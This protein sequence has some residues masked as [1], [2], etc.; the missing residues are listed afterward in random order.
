MLV[1]TPAADEQEP[2]RCLELDDPLLT[3]T[4]DA[5]VT[6]RGELDRSVEDDVT[7]RF[8]VAAESADNI[9]IDA[10]EVTFFDAAGVRAF[11]LSQQHA[12]D[13]GVGVTFRFARPGPVDRVL[14]LVGLVHQF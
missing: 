14:D 7:R 3:I 12:C 11:L 5:V 10:R 9:E 6:L 1:S 8:A 13:H 4:I 2:A